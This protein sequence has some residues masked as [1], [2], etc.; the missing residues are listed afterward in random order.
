[1]TNHAQLLTNY[2]F[3]GLIVNWC[4]PSPPSD[5]YLEPY[6]STLEGAKVN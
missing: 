5:G 1:M 2:C 3:D 4:E 6:T